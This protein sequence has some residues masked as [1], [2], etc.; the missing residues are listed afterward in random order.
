MHKYHPDLS[1][2]PIPDVPQIGRLEASHFSL[3]GGLADPSDGT[4]GASVTRVAREL[5]K[6]DL[7]A[8]PDDLKKQRDK[9]HA[10]FNPERERELDIALISEKSFGDIPWSVASSEDGEDLAVA[11]NGD[12]EVVS[13]PFLER[14]FLFVHRCTVRALC[15]ST[16]GKVLA[17][18]ATDWRIRIWDVSL[19]S[20]EGLVLPNMEDIFSPVLKTGGPKFGTLTKAEALTHDFQ[21]SDIVTD[22]AYSPNG[23]VAVA[24]SRDKCICVWDIL[25]DQRVGYFNPD[26]TVYSV[27]FFSPPGLSLG[28][29]SASFDGTIKFWA[30]EELNPTGLICLRTLSG[31]TKDHVLSATYNRWNG[32]IISGSE[33]GSVYFWD[34]L[35]GDPELALFGHE[36]R[37]MKVVVG[38]L[39]FGTDYVAESLFTTIG[40]D[41]KVRVWRSYSWRNSAVTSTGDLRTSAAAQLGKKKKGI[42]IN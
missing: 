18:G 27:K 21:T 22:V 41:G 13:F 9:W 26:D 14:K 33:D 31:H 20:F 39:G 23:A 3:P 29:L 5:I 16:D 10:V 1:D 19:E 28:L 38:R 8:L 34:P 30:F 2:E 6:L 17:T 40:R 25:S 37:V 11:V 24:A 35:T 36:G 42:I 15:F 12:V 32:R 4:I 7:N